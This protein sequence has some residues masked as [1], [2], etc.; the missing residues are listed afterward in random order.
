[1]AVPSTGHRC[2]QMP[3]GSTLKRFFAKLAKQP[4]M[5]LQPIGMA[6]SPLERHLAK[7]M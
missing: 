3:H 1:M 5:V 2:P 6:V 4:E 7:L